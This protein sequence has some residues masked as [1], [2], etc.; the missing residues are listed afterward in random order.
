MG[1]ES[2]SVLVK[3]DGRVVCMKL[4]SSQWDEGTC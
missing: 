1:D 4:M 2:I 3:F